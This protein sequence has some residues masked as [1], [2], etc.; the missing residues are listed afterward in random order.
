MTVTKQDVIVGPELAAEWLAEDI[1][2]HNRKKKPGAMAK[3]TQD[4]KNGDWIDELGEP[5][6]FEEADSFGREFMLN[7]QNRLE[8]IVASGTVHVFTIIRG[9]PRSAQNVMDSGAARSI[10]DTLTMTGHKYGPKLAAAARQIYL[11]EH[12][13]QWKASLPASNA[14]IV[15]R[16]KADWPLVDAIDQVDKIWL[17]VRIQPAVAAVGWYFGSK[18]EPEMTRLSFRKLRS[19]ANMDQGDP[20]LALRNRLNIDGGLTR[21]Q[22][23]FVV[24]RALNHARRG[25][26]ATR[27]QLPRGTKVGA[28]EVVREYQALTTERI[29]AGYQ[30][31]EEGSQFDTKEK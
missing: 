22:Q 9:L 11:I 2:K 21:N 14:W 30:P 24:A 12:P 13:D 3:Y 25:N 26:E 7:G 23:L 17:D 31:G 16:I 27:M 15:D 1:N 20:I 29:K 5:I 28:A 6:C 18:L 19:G 8:A 10:G 4:M